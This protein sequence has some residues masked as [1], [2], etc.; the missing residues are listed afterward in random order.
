M[1][2]GSAA[3]DRADDALQAIDHRGISWSDVRQTRYWIHKR[4]H[5]SYPGPI[6]D[7]RQR[8]VVVPPERYGDQVLESAHVSLEGAEG[9]QQIA[10][11]VF[12]NHLLVFDIPEVQG[13]VCF[14]I[15]LRLKRSGSPQLRPRLDADQ[16]A[17]FRTPTPLTAS[18][19]RLVEVA[20]ALAERHPAP[21]DLAEAIN[22]WVFGQMRYGWGVTSVQTSAAEALALGQGLCQDYAH[23]MLAL[24]RTA[25][26]AARYVSGHL[27]GEGGSH[28]WVEVLLP[29][30]QGFVAVPFDP[31]HRRLANLSYL[32]I[33]VGRDYRDVAPTSGSFRA[34]YQ[35][36]LTATKRASL[37]HV[38]YT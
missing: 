34:P 11:D 1:I 21:A 19:A 4:F 30:D 31:T 8:L 2:K 22:A 20:Q 27:L 28:A 18:D 35:G 26:L 25:G 5:Y 9:T 7:L 3:L 37:T 10:A 32:T 29:Q 6:R 33:A 24:C 14:D 15:A 38:E 23:I 17:P 16:A 12:G 13:E 36:R